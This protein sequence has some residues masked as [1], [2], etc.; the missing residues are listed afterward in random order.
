MGDTSAIPCQRRH[1]YSKPRAPLKGQGP[2]NRDYPSE[3]AGDIP[4]NYQAVGNTDREKSY[5][6]NMYLR[7]SRVLDYL[8]TRADWDGKTIVLTGG[9][10]GG[11]DAGGDLEDQRVRILTRRRPQLAGVWPRSDVDRP[12]SPPRPHLLGDE[13]QEGGEQAELGGQGQRQAGPG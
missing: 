3:P 7:D 1:N 6:L 4:R 5:F 12:L 2:G 11:Q 10:M 8:L 13:G 9:S